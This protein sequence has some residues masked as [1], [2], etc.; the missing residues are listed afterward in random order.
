MKNIITLLLIGA[1]LTS[2]AGDPTSPPKAPTI[3]Q[4]DVISLFSDAYTDVTVNTWRTGWSNATLTDTNLNGNAVKRYSALDFVGVETVGANSIDVSNMNYIHLDVWTGNATTF[5]IKLVDFGPNNMFQGG[6]DSEHEIAF[7]SPKQDEWISYHIDLKDFANLTGRAN[8]SQIIFSGLPTGTA[9]VWIDNVYFTTKALT[10][11]LAEPK[12]AAM[13]P[14]RDTADVISLYSDTFPNVGVDTFRT[15]WS[16]AALERVMVAGNN[17]LKY[18]ALTFVGI[19]TT[20]ANLID[21]SSMEHFNFDIWSPNSTTFKVKLVDFG[22]DGMFQGG[23][24][25]EHE[26]T[27]DTITKETWMNFHIPLSDFTG[28][29]AKSNIAQII[30][31]SEPNGTSVVYMDNIHFS[32]EPVV[33]VSP[34]EFDAFN[35]FPN[36]AKETLNLNIKGSFDIQSVSLT[37]LQGRTVLEIPVNGTQ[38]NERIDIS[39]VK[40]GVYLVAVATEAGVHH[41]KLIIQ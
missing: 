15:P 11:P 36:P 7:T 4:A 5:R 1:A 29:T 9:D 24:D 39:S 13:Q 16:N 21:A 10:A 23:D 19:E 30:F 22:A 8:I 3:P 35:I 25:T 40:S 20:G 37:D 27:F 6:D 2:F 18:S 38:V 34:I 17:V 41:Q 28:L 26:L 14:K 32:K 31:V 12:V 33:S